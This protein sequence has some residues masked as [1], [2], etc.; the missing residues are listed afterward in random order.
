VLKLALTTNIKKDFRFNSFISFTDS[1]S[2]IENYKKMDVIQEKEKKLD[3]NWVRE[4]LENLRR[5][6]GAVMWLYL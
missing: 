4:R 3:T 5:R 2:C 6:S 1:K